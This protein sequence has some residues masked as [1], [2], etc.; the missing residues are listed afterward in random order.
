[1]NLANRL[2]RLE[3]RLGPPPPPMSQQVRDRAQFAAFSD[4]ELTSLIDRMQASGAASLGDLFV[5]GAP[6]LRDILQRTETA[7]NAAALEM[8]GKSYAELLREEAEGQQ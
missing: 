1:M 5:E 8:T 6:E 3:Q 7:V 4:E 2:K